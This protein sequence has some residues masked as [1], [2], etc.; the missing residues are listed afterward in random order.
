MKIFE[1]DENIK[2]KIE[3]IYRSNEEMAPTGGMMIDEVSM[4]ELRRHE[5]HFPT[6]ICM[7][8]WK[9]HTFSTLTHVEI[10]VWRHELM[11]CTSIEEKTKHS[12][13]SVKN[14]S[15]VGMF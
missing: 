15:K 1:W 4:S 10:R 13:K 5:L 7:G 3:R 11:K 9:Y 12:F 14:L 6:G 2:N 8:S